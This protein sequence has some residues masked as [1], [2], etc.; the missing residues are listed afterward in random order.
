MSPSSARS[1][2]PAQCCSVAFFP[3]KHLLTHA[4]ELGAITLREVAGTPHWERQKSPVKLRAFADVSEAGEASASIPQT[5][6][7]RI[8]VPEWTWTEG[9]GR[10]EGGPMNLTRAVRSW[11]T[12][13]RKDHTKKKSY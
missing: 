8:L 12:R 4:R 9:P 11:S 5:I 10:S 6:N 1:A 2:V 3:A 7:T 13:G